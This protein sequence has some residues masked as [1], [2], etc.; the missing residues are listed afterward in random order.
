MLKAFKED[1]REKLINRL[2]RWCKSTLCVGCGVGWSEKNS[3]KKIGTWEKI[4]EKKWLIVNYWN[5]HALCLGV[6]LREEEKFSCI[7]ADN[8]VANSSIWREIK[9]TRI[10]DAMDGWLEI[11]KKLLL[12]EDPRQG[13]SFIWEFL[14]Y[15][16]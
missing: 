4:C 16:K 7:I 13:H 3:I 12:T 11:L 1:D 6:E 10:D 8:L 2:R 14:K 9:L 15:L 5:V